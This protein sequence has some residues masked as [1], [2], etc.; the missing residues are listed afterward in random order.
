VGNKALEEF[1][2]RL[3]R[4][5]ELCAQLRELYYKYLDLAAFRSDKCFF[6]GR[7]CRRSWKRQYDVG[8]LTLMWTYIL[9]T[10]PLCGKLIRALAEVEYEIRRRALESLRN[11]GG[12]IRRTKPDTKNEILSFYLKEPARVYLVL[13][14]G[15]HYV[16]WGG[17]NGS[18]K[19]GSIDIDDKIVKNIAEQY[20]CGKRVTVDVI[21]L[22]VDGGEEYERLWLEVPT[23]E[24]VSKLLGGK[25]RAPVALFRNLGWLLSD[26]WRKR[27][28]H[29]AGNPG[30]AAVR[31]FDW[32]ALAKYVIDVLKIAPDAPLVFSLT[33]RSVTVSGNVVNPTIEMRPIG[34]AAKAIRLAYAYF[35]ITLGGT[36]EVLA[37]GYS[38]MRAL[39]EE[40]FRWDG[41]NYV[42]D[43]PGAW[44]AYSSI[45][46]TLITGDGYAMPTSLGV[47]AK[48]T[49]SETLEERKVRVKELARALGGVATKAARLP[50]WQIR[51]LLPASPTPVF[52]KT[53]KVYNTI[54]NYPAIAV[55][56][57][58][59]TRFVLY[60]MNEGR[61]AINLKE[62]TELYDA[63]KC[64]G[65]KAKIW[66]NYLILSFKLLNELRSSGAIVRFFNELEKEAIR[67]TRP[68]L[69]LLE[70]ETV[71]SVLENVI[72]IAK[73][74]IA[75]DKRRTYIRIIPNDKSRLEEISTMLKLA[76]VSHYML[77]RKEVRVYG[78]QMVELL[79]TV[80]SEFFPNVRV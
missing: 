25:N 54:T 64:L 47:S 11:Y 19:G 76:G 58:G 10:A 32:I 66:R 29:T 30:Q 42:V 1:F 23:P 56:E 28:G 48:L 52:E 38:L 3:L 45:V 70:L 73:I 49:A 50:K 55:V 75:R 12:R 79:L 77:R 9:N 39:R 5:D 40:A 72:K 14:N 80:L 41:R 60:H 15:R 6:P 34:I 51:L 59:N 2:E 13:W 7:K 57:F 31:L 43:D 62:A 22:D 18:P 27:L 36:E 26:D 4:W 61:F 74:V 44:I 78:R 8:D 24:S 16:V 46:T 35:G 68:A 37:R 17:F 71:K 65:L 63:V 53:V 67:S 33:V 21:E 69:S 20:R